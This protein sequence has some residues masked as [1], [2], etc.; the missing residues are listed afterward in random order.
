MEEM[1]DMIEMMFIEDSV[2]VWFRKGWRRLWIWW[3]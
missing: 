1:L 2:R 3:I